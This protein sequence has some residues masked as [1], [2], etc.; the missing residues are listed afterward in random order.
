MALH[1]IQ[2]KV[3]TQKRFHNLLGN[4][5]GTTDL[6]TYAKTQLN[7]TLS[8]QLE[9]Q[10]CEVQMGI[11]YPRIARPQLINNS[12]IGGLTNGPLYI[13]GENMATTLPH[14]AVVLANSLNQLSIMTEELKTIMRYIQPDHS[15]LATYGHQMRNVLLLAAMEFENE[16]KGVLRI[17]GYNAP[18]DRFSTNDFVKLHGP[19]RLAEYTVQLTNYPSLAPI[20]PFVGWTD[21]APTQSL[22]WYDSYNAVKH[23]REIHF[24]KATL[25]AAINAVSTVAIMLCAEYRIIEMW[26]DQIGE[27]FRFKEHPRWEDWQNYLPPSQGE[28]WR[29][30]QFQF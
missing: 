16:C 11:F 6:D 9:I 10:P 15:N 20:A 19:L 13:H 26:R 4:P 8:N 17:N 24:S 2:I 7:I 12:Y 21:T 1:T 25:E 3:C 28:N 30:M 5:P 29:Q 14:D 18:N 23:D 22:I 27:F